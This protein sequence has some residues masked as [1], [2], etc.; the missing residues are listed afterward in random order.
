MIK[1]SEYTWR[2]SGSSKCYVCSSPILPDG[3]YREMISVN[4]DIWDTDFVK[5]VAHINC[6]SDH[7]E[8]EVTTDLALASSV[9][10]KLNY[11]RTRYE[12]PAWYHHTVMINVGPLMGRYGF[13]VS[14]G[15]L[16]VEK[17]G[18][19]TDDANYI[20]VR[21]DGEQH[22]NSYHPRDLGWG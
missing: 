4:V 5:R 15:N 2:K 1:V 22:A 21:V 11:I 9:N 18:T 16:S 8:W 3:Q 20:E 12:V 14:G 7:E 10:G 19:F 17:Y 6:V 13:I